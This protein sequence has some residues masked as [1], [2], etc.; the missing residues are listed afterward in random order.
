MRTARLETVHASLSMATTRCH[1]GG[2]GPQIN[3]FEQVSNG[4]MGPKSDVRGLYSEAQC[5]MGNCHVGDPPDGGHAPVKNT[6]FH[7]LRWRAVKN[8]CLKIQT[9]INSC[10]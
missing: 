1:W 7:Q 3:K 9:A 10:E 5:I 6:T 4:V 8:I 2:V